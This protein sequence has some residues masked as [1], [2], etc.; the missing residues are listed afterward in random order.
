MRVRAC[1]CDYKLRYIIS[2]VLVCVCVCV[3]VCSFVVV[4]AAVVVLTLTSIPS[5]AGPIGQRL[6]GIIPYGCVFDAVGSSST[7]GRHNLHILYTHG[8]KMNPSR[9]NLHI[10][11]THTVR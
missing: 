2:L 6:A 11:Y 10:L 3:C 5:P 1:T 4:V 7:S 9:N 8:Q